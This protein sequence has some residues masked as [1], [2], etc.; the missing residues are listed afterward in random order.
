MFVLDS[1]L[2]L[3][4]VVALHLTKLKYPNFLFFCKG[5]I[6]FLPP[7]QEP[8]HKNPKKKPDAEIKIIQIEYKNV[9]DYPMAD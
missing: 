4:I 5:S 3:L 2:L 6:L 7:D 9:K 8:E 1:L